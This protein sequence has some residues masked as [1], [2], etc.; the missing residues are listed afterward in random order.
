[1]K[2][3]TSLNRLLLSNLLF[4]LLMLAPNAARAKSF[5]LFLEPDAKEVY[6]E[7][8]GKSLDLHIFYPEDTVPAEPA[9][10]IVFFH[11]GG[12]SKGQ[13]KSFYFACDYFASRGMVAMSVRYR[14]AKGKDKIKCL[15]D[16]KSA[17]RY[18]KK[19]A[20]RFG[21][22]PDRIVSAGGSAGGSLAGAVATSKIINEE[23][24][25]LSITIDPVALVLFNPIGVGTEKPS[26]FML[27][28]PEVT[29]DFTPGT[30]LHSDM[31]PVLCLWGEKDKFVGPR[32]MKRFQEAVQALG[33]RCE[34][35]IY[36]GQAHSFFDNTREWVITTLNRADVFLES[37]DILKGAPRV[38]QWLS[39]IG[40]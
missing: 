14:L 7:I 4:L 3:H 34:I 25:D 30:S 24:D 17:M 10:A 21:I 8:E 32:G 33:V 28:S 6:K 36:P 39:N 9:P 19:N 35:E 5:Q 11:G 12:F 22:D 29:A 16:A 23:T 20:D 26:G 2:N 40:K 31:P 13:P 15:K 1:M 18:I 27:W 37:V 38:E